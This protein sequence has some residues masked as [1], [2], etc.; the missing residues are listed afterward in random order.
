MSEGHS[1]FTQTDHGSID[2]SG[3]TGISAGVGSVILVHKSNLLNVGRYVG[4][5]LL[6]S[7][8]PDDILK[9]F[10]PED[11]TVKKIEIII[12]RND[13][14]ATH[15]RFLA[16]GSEITR[17]VDLPVIATPTMYRYDV[18]YDVNSGN[19]LITLAQPSGTSNT[20]IGLVRVSYVSR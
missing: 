18:D 5:N 1:K 19:Y 4:Y 6:E 2:H 16:G 10:T 8:N 12:N 20:E 15:V 14:A 9:W 7:P 17:T 13:I 11:I 3:L